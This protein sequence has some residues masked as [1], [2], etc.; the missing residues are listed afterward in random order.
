MS[1]QVSVID[2]ETHES[3]SFTFDPT[4]G[5]WY[6]RTEYRKFHDI[7]EFFHFVK[8]AVMHANENWEK[9]KNESNRN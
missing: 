8:T 7:D 2:R 6:P 4:Y 3:R 9:I 5:N 1:L